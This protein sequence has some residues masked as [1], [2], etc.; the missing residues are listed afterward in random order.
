MRSGS[1]VLIEAMLRR[2]DPKR[3]EP[4]TVEIKER[5]REQL[6]KKGARK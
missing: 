3:P 1:V 2:T 5:I 6:W 4:G